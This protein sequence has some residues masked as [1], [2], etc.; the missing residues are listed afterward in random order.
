MEGNSDVLEKTKYISGSEIW[1]KTKGN[2]C[3]GRRN[4]GHFEQMHAVTRIFTDDS[5]DGRGQ[6]YVVNRTF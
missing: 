4:S 2:R 6:H 5:G 3:E 1:G